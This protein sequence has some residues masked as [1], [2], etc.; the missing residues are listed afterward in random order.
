M[1]LRSAIEKAVDSLFQGQRSTIKLGRVAKLTKL[2]DA[3]VGYI[4]CEHDVVPALDEVTKR[5]EG[6]YQLEDWSGNDIIPHSFLEDDC[7]RAFENRLVEACR[8]RRPGEQTTFTWQE[9]WALWKSK[10]QTNYGVLVTAWHISWVLTGLREELQPA[11]DSAAPK[12]C[13]VGRTWE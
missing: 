4:S 11:L 1:K 6:L 13:S 7:Q 2:R 8:Q 12:S 9:E 5:V 10:V 3:N